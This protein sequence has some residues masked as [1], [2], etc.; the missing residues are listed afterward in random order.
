MKQKSRESRLSR[1][2]W[3]TKFLSTLVIL[4]C[5][6]SSVH[7]QLEGQAVTTSFFEDGYGNIMGGPVVR[8]INIH[9]PPYTGAHW[10]A[11]QES[12][13]W[14]SSVLGQ[15][16]GI[17]ISSKTNDI[18]VTASTSYEQFD[19]RNQPLAFGSAGS[20]GVYKLNPTTGA[21]QPITMTV[22]YNTSIVLNSKNM[23]NGTPTNPGPGLGNICYDEVHD[24]LFVSNF[25]DGKIYRIDAV[26]EI[27]DH[28]YDPVVSANYGGTTNPALLADNGTEGMVPAG[29]RVWGL[30][31]NSKENRLYYGVWVKSIF[32]V[33][34]SKNNVIRSVKLDELGEII[35]NTDK[36]EILIDNY[37]RNKSSAIVSDMSF[38]YV[39]GDIKLAIA[40]KA[41][42]GSYKSWAHMSK[43][44]LYKKSCG[45]SNWNFVRDYVV[46]ANT[47][48]SS[49]NGQNSGGGIDFGY[50]TFNPTATPQNT[51]DD[52]RIWFSSDAMLNDPTVGGWLYGMHSSPTSGNNG[53]NYINIGHFIDYDNGYLPLPGQSN[54]EYYEDKHQMGDVEIFRVKNTLPGDLALDAGEDKTICA[55]SSVRLGG[56]PTVS[57]GF[58]PIS[59]EWSNDKGTFF[60]LLD[61]P[62]DS[63]TE[64]TTYYVEATDGYGCLHHDEVIITVIGGTDQTI[65]DGETVTL[66]GEGQK[67]PTVKERVE[68]YDEDGNLIGTGH[69]VSVTPTETSGYYWTYELEDGTKCSGKVKV[70]VYPNP[71]ADA[72]EDKITCGDREV[73]L[74]GANT[75]SGGTPNYTYQWVTLIGTEDPTPSDVANPG[76]TSTITSTYEVTVTDAH[77]CSDKDDVNVVVRPKPIAYAGE[78]RTLCYGGST[79]LGGPSLLNHSYYWDYWP[80]SPTQ[81]IPDE[82]N[83]TVTPTVTTLY[84]LFVLDDLTRCYTEDQVMVTVEQVLTID[85]GKDRIIC[86]GQLT[87][88]GGVPT[89]SGGTG[90]YIYN[91]NNSDVLNIS[92]P[93]DDPV[94]NTLYHL[95]V[96]DAN[97]CIGSDDVEVRVNDELIVDAGEDRFIC[98]GASTVLGGSPVV[99]SGGS[100][101]YTYEWYV[102][103]NTI[104][105]SIEDNPSVNPVTSTIYE[106]FVTDQATGCTSTDQI[107]VVVYGRPSVSVSSDQEICEGESV[108]LNAYSSGS[109]NTYIWTP[110]DDLSCSECSNPEATPSSTTIYC[111]RVINSNGCSSEHINN[112]IT[113]TVN[114]APIA[115]A[116]PDITSC[117]GTVSTIGGNATASGGTPGYL[118]NWS[119]TSSTSS[120]PPI[121]AVTN[122]A[123]N[124]IV[125]DSKGCTATDD[126]VMTVV[127]ITE[128]VQDGGFVIGTEP[129]WRGQ[130]DETHT[131]NTWFASAGGPDLFDKRRESCL[132]NPLPNVDVCGISPADINCI[133]IP[134]NHFGY[135]DHYTNPNAPVGRYAG[136]YFAL[137]TSGKGYRLQ[138]DPIDIDGSL[139]FIVEGIEQELAQPLVKGNTY[140]ID[141][142]ASLAEYGEVMDVLTADEAYF[143]VKLSKAK[144]LSGNMINVNSPVS[145]S[146]LPYTPSGGDLIFTGRITDKDLWQ[147]V[148]YQFKA[149][150]NYTHLIIESTHPQDLQARIESI[151]EN[152]P[153][154]EIIDKLSI[155]SYMFIDDISIKE[156]VC[157]S[158]GST[159]VLADAGEDRAF[160]FN[161]QLGVVLG[162]D[163]TAQF[164]VAPYTYKWFKGSNTNSFSNLSNPFLW[165]NGP[166]TYT[167]K[168]TDALGATDTDVMNLY[169]SSPNGNNI[170]PNFGFSSG[171]TPTGRDQIAYANSWEAAT[172]TPDL[173]DK[174][175]QFNC[176]PLPCEARED[177]RI[178]TN[179]FGYQKDT[180]L[181]SEER[182]IGLWYF[183]SEAMN[184]LQY[185]NFNPSVQKILNLVPKDS[186]IVEGAQ[187]Q[188]SSPLKK[189]LIYRVICYA[190]LA[191]KGEIDRGE[192]SNTLA[193]TG[194][195]LL[196]DRIEL[197]FKYGNGELSP[198]PY[199]ATN[200]AVAKRVNVVEREKWQKIEFGFTPNEDS[201]YF[202]IETSGSFSGDEGYVYIDDVSIVEDCSVPFRRLQIES[203]EE[204]VVKSNIKLFPNPT[205]GELNIQ[206]T[207]D[208]EEPAF[209]QVY[210]ID[211]K[212][213]SQKQ[214]VDVTNNGITTINLSH[215]PQG[216][217]YVELSQG[218]QVIRERIVVQ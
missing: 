171:P 35:P 2:A 186:R 7:A 17:A 123:C 45:D 177:V 204:T 158:A 196:A 172:G 87:Q 127:G 71:T 148:N 98:L 216:I 210:T 5:S 118:Y 103:G 126:M 198:L 211:A 209:V 66:G 55:G 134:C 213:V 192:V 51:G 109:G 156:T 82:S 136:L 85:A 59:I 14:N 174:D 120:N 115:D 138:N 95:E 153:V 199:R 181:V 47:S 65:C 41:M 178:P 182:Y 125:T 33:D 170:V 96:T 8:L 64:T 10:E 16:F 194:D 110:T 99:L 184:E 56:E 189:G 37:Y 60:S 117:I 175:V 102:L 137:K 128:Y 119:C 43:A 107:H 57:G 1:L 97:N 143:V 135:Q 152:T 214:A 68:W 18:Y 207:T 203:S 9:N 132:P 215:L 145:G 217:Y 38:S 212:L 3:L 141:L 89:A 112:C 190:S 12:Y 208:S 185:V 63:P 11:P 197:S 155:Q 92:N 49:L 191:E 90:P 27:I 58:G 20:G 72:G 169:A 140:C 206:L 146:Y 180:T 26:T 161:Q 159:N 50:T 32:D 149:N 150:E 116:G 147:N 111:V 195:P 162:G 205:S 168:V 42:S 179:Y 78:D 21:V 73:I 165:P 40:S 44:S 15:V 48:H 160:C 176:N 53:I 31:Y 39:D 187:V 25:E 94:V 104:L 93:F 183:A 77:G 154:Q 167:V 29:D 105:F 201:D 218:E 19:Y 108:W 144:T 130:L 75:A 74:G 13:V 79:Q 22:P 114:P 62:Y 139:S 28:I 106:I 142:M 36:L 164:G 133:D 70:T 100:G 124:L 83:P 6:I 76:V 101:V 129:E 80:S 151:N 121:T 46:G 86:S 188:L 81:S 67:P 131:N 157:C 23:P 24:K 193:S 30:A 84:T 113:V 88:L 54:P 200:N 202:V 34:A 52:E 166:T 163:P 91:W 4:V 173:F 122:S 69:T 61:N